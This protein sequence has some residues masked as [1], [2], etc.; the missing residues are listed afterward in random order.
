[1]DLK[2]M[3]DNLRRRVGNPSAGDVPDTILTNVL[4]RAY[5]DLTAR[6][7]FHRVRKICQ[8]N[9]IVG[10]ARYGIPSDCFAV[11]R[12]RD[13]TNGKRI[14]K[15][16]DTAYSDRSDTTA[17]TTN[18]RPTRYIRQRDWIALDPP[19][20]GA[21]QIEMFYKAKMAD[22]ADDSDT[23]VIPEQ[24]HEGIVRLGRFY[25][26]DDIGD[27]PKSQSS[28]AIFDKWAQEMPTEFDDEAEAIDTGVEM[29]TLSGSQA[30]NLDFDSSP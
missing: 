5:S 1:M 25:Y 13:N 4:N 20:D 21:Y 29:P 10:Q 7:K 18:G 17:Q 14:T 30:K 6:F 12:V 9:T 3:R 28:L 23:P 16:G 22:L 26:W 11:L 24:W 2:T 19:P 8:F 27:L 15:I